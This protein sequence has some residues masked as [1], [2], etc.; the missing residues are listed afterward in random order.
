MTRGVTLGRRS[1]GRSKARPAEPGGAPAVAFRDGVQLAGS[2]VW[3]DATRARDLNFVSHAHLGARGAHHKVLATGRTMAL[4]GAAGGAPVGEVLTTPFGRPFSLGPLRLELFPS[5][6]VPGAASLLLV[7]P[8]GRR[9]AY[10][11][12][13]NP[14]ASLGESA[15]VRGA[16][17]LVLE[18]PLAPVAGRLPPRAETLAALVELVKRALAD[19]RQP[20]VLAPALGTSEEAMVALAQ[21]GVPL[22]VH[23]RVHAFAATLAAAGI[24]VPA[25][26][27][28]SSRM[29]RGEVLIGPPDGLGAARIARLERPLTIALTG[30]AL[31][32]GAAADLGVDHALPLADHADL[33]ALVTYVRHSEAR[34]VWLTAGHCPALVA[35]LAALDVTARPLG[36]PRQM[37]LLA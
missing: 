12:D 19:G 11:G 36:P 16:D 35:A 31:G 23:P 21:A 34:E 7:E 24:A 4:I 1:G 22:R 5:G 17:V 37:E 26:A 9:I 10:A 25:A 8:S 18:A 33:D 27:R 3:C 14:V 15:E 29:G 30:L 13:V 2:V 28:F 32:A 20:V 6:H